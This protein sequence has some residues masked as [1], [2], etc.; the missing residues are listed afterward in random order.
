V[1]TNKIGNY[2]IKY[3]LKI[4]YLCVNKT[5]VRNIYVKDTKKPDLNI[6][7]DKQITLYI[8]D[9]FNYPTF[10]AIDNYDG[11]ITNKVKVSSNLD[12]NKEGT[13]EINYTISDS[14]NNVT[15]EKILIN[16][17]K[18]R[19]NAYI[20]VSIT[21]QTLYYYE[22]DKLVLTTPVVTG[23]NNAT[24]TGNFK[25]LSKSRNVTLK[26]PDY[27]SFVNYWIAFIGHTYGI[28]DASWRNA[29]GGT[30]YKNNGSHGCI[31]TPYNKAKQLYDLVDIGTPVYVYN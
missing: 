11:D 7:S 10:S 27:T 26:G 9:S 22:Y 14:S 25:V 1:N 12:L 15:E 30:I 17:A 21:D 8:G 4:L 6:E 18:K 16:V 29:F 23:K 5:L 28:H 20:K 13:Y 24:P 19:K 31:N 2:T 3:N